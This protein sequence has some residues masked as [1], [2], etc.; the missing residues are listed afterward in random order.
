MCS[1][2]LAE[3]R[4]EAGRLPGGSGPLLGDPPGGARLLLASMT[5][6][7]KPEPWRL[8]RPRLLLVRLVR[9]R[10]ALRLLLRSWFTL[11]SICK[12]RAGGQ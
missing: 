11:T 3:R 6:L 10:K 7:K 4:G 5:T 8:G 1:R 2:T 9:A 12:P